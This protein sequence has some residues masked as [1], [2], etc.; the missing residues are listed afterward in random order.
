MQINK[1]TKTGLAIAVI[2]L[3]SILGAGYHWGSVQIIADG[4]PPSIMESYCTSGDLAYMSGK[5]KLTMFFTENIGVQ[6]ATATIYKIGSLNRL[7]DKVEEIQLTETNVEGD[8]YQ[9]DGRAT[10]ALEA[11]KEYYVVYRVTDT[12][13]HS[14]TYGKDSVGRGTVRIKLVELTATCYI[15]DVKIEN[16]HDQI[17]I[18]TLNV[19]FK[20]TIDSGSPSDVAKIYAIIGS[21]KIQ[22]SKQGQSYYGFYTLPED[23]SYNCIVQLEE[24]GGGK[25][26]LASFN[27]TLGT[28]YQ[29][30]VV[31]ATL[32]ML[33]VA[34]IWYSLDPEQKKGLMR[35]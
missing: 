5:P 30:T 13:G 12:A 26:R 3:A 28:Q 18:D 32:G 9:Y 31:F 35:Q 27:I 11:N 17:V 33:L 19:N 15:N 8:E 25:T 16:T 34:T 22:L 6:S 10:K 24:A 29:N 14:D 20:V 23:G 1:D 21:D 4:T 7:G 2:V